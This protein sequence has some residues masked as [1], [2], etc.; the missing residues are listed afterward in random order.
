MS[1]SY[2]ECLVKAEQKSWAKAVKVLLII[3][4]VLLVF[5]AIAAAQFM[6]FIGAVA[7]GVAIYFFN[8][9][10]KV[11]YEY[12]YLDKE[13]SVDAIYN[14][15]RRK[16]VATYSVSNIEILAPIKSYHLD[17]YRNRQ[18]SGV[19]DYSIGRVEQP[20]LRYE[21]YLEGNSKVILSPSEELIKVL[22]NVAPRKVFSE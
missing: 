16:T 7:V 17:N 21:M 6:A 10:T 14:Q 4:V 19:K 11:E 5:F 18:V 2:V 22:K 15:T 8:M 9:F 12:L 3:F 1:D 20:D 13:I